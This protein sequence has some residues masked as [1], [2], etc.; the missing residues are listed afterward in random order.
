LDPGP[1]EHPFVDRESELEQLREACTRSTLVI[2]HGSP[3]V[4]KSRLAHE[5]FPRDGER[6]SWIDVSMMRNPAD[7]VSATGRTL[8]LELHSDENVEAGVRRIGS[9]LEARDALD[10]LV[11]DDFDPLAEHASELLGRWETAAPPNLVVT[12]RRQLGIAGATPVEV[13][14]MDRA[15]AIELFGTYARKVHPGFELEPQRD[16]VGQLVDALDGLPYAIELAARRA[17]VLSPADM[18]DRLDERFA[19]LRDRRN[20]DREEM[21]LALEWTWQWLDRPERQFLKQCCAVSSPASSDALEAAVVLDDDV[22]WLDTLDA[23]VAKS[24]IQRERVDALDG[25][26]RFRLLNTVRAFVEQRSVE[27]SPATR[28]KEAERRAAEHFWRVATELGPAVTGPDG[29]DALDILDVDRPHFFAAAEYWLDAD[30][31]RGVRLVSSLRHVALLRGPLFQ[32]APLFELAAD[33]AEGLGLSEAEALLHA[34]LAEIQSKRGH[35]KRA[36]TA[37][38]RAQR[39]A[40]EQPPEV[41]SHVQ[42]V[43]GAIEAPNDAETARRLLET[44]LDHAETTD[45]SFLK[46]RAHEQLGYIDIR[47]FQLAEAERG[48]RRAREL[49]DAG[50]CPLLEAD[51][52]AGLAYVQQRQNRLQDAIRS[53]ERAADV[54]EQ[55]DARTSRAK[56]TFD[57]GVCRHIVGA[58]A[59]AEENLE[60][61]LDDWRRLGL[62]YYVAA[63][64]YQLAL[65]TLE[66]AE[67]AR[68]RKLLERARRRAEDGGDTQTAAKA[69]GFRALYS[70]LIEDRG[71]A[72]RLERARAELDA[73]PDPDATAAFC[74]GLVAMTG[75]DTDDHLPEISRIEELIALLA[76]SDHYYEEVLGR[77]LAIARS[78]DQCRAARSAND[79]SIRRER[80]QEAVSELEGVFEF[81]S[82]TDITSDLAAAS[83]PYVRL[84]GAKLART[85]D[86][87]G[88][89]VDRSKPEA[90]HLLEVHSNCHW[91]CVDDGKPVDI[92]SRKSN[93]LILK[94]LIQ[95]HLD[96]P[97]STLGIE[98]LIDAGWPDQTLSFEAGR[99]RV[100]AAIQFLRNHGLSEVVET[101]DDGYRIAQNV[102]VQVAPTTG[103]EA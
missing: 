68:C 71:N 54:H 40:E 22:S 101:T 27:G 53:F 103:L 94:S 12:T 98:L 74:V 102:D 97:D 13:P 93:R 38:R 2:I 19:L 85:L 1:S 7:L 62:Q 28:L 15:A 79:G 59:D 24:W 10:A 20:D 52:L 57:L 51:S 35:R 5:A 88:V 69:I 80:A 70:W 44:A 4:G 25:T 84:L 63:G 8:D 66:R 64:D 89:A 60:A 6:S 99:N 58:L 47:L 43:A 14:P 32:Y 55:N 95:K 30:D 33:T 91:Y 86:D 39:L 48:F 90:D 34:D 72:D 37:V 100:Y 83:N 36:V 18:V 81:D 96:D 45:N 82:R 61:A 75:A 26:F 56:V 92:A 42:R 9:A 77:L 21:E 73:G 23:L 50:R 67:H 17:R 41:R 3:G 31:E 16:A 49:F 78:L 87:L 29:L 65:I 76:P 11:F 46:A